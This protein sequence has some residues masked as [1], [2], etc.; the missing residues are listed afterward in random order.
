[1]KLA[2]A[3][4][5]NAPAFHF[6]QANDFKLITIQDAKILST[7]DLHDDTHTHQAR[8]QFL[9]DLGV[10]ALICNGIG[11]GAVDRLAAVGI[12]MY[13]FNALSVPDAIRAFVSG[14][15]PQQT[16]VFE[17]QC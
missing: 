17:C 7:Q 15:L 12:A 1:M 9:K 11:S 10:D 13:G 14:T 6:G 16:D 8:P 5:N 2:V 4:I 3:L